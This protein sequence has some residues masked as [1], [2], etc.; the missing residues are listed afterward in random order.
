MQNPSQNQVNNRIKEYFALLKTKTTEELHALRDSILNAFRAERTKVAPDQK[1]L[2]NQ[3]IKLGLI[4]R[5]IKSR[6][7]IDSQDKNQ[8]VQD[9]TVGALK[10]KT[11]EEKLKE[12]SLDE[13]N[14]MLANGKRKL[15]YLEV[16]K[17]E[18][19][20]T[21][22]KFA[23]I[24]TVYTH[25]TNKTN[26]IQA[27]INTRSA[28]ASEQAKQELKADS[29]TQGKI[30]GVD[31][32]YVWAGIAGGIIAGAIGHN[33]GKSMM[34][35]ALVGVGVGGGLVWLGKNVKSESVTP[36]TA[37]ASTVNP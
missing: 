31:S 30:F 7:P 2:K 25:F 21:P 35:F 15:A 22:E 10:P 18:P 28:S 9:A 5:V 24:T 4:G 3:N 19:N 29:G 33:M 34:G 32:E 12:K 23:N 13:L 36:A 17:S 37:V 8:V 6:Q 1:A 20:I 27:E 11:F 26:A 16:S 14:T